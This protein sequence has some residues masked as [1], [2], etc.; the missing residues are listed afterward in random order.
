MAVT[1]N[2]HWK[3]CGCFEYCIAQKLVH[4]V[5]VFEWRHSSGTAMRRSEAAH[6]T[7]DWVVHLLYIWDVW[8][9]DWVS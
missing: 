7:F 5:K 1:R 6:T 4:V 3:C 2:W 9:E 8:L